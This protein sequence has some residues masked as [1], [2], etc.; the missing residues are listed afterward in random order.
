MLGVSIMPERRFSGTGPVPGESL[1]A[2]AIFRELTP[3]V[4]AMLSQRC[5][6]RSYSP[7]QMILQ[8]QDEGRD[9]YF[10]VRGRVCAVYYS[11][12]GREVHF[13]DL[14]AG[15]IFGEFAAIDGKSRATDIVS[16]TDALI[17][18]MSA[19][20]FWEVLRRYEPVCAATL[21]RL[22]GIARA[23]V[24]RVVELST[25]PVRSRVHSELLRLAGSGARGPNRTIAIINPAPTHAEIASRIST[26]REAVTRELN[27]LAR[28]DLIEKRGTALVIRDIGALANMVQGALEEPPL[29]KRR[30]A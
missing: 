18:R 15:E 30:A 21:R 28:A 19:D 9:V 22:T 8:S 29:T 5:R 17:A 25:L 10:V 12:S 1:A 14:P 20:L 3:E 6:W 23:A 7:G 24:Q 11:A 26:H 27:S 13:N 2:I 4:I 16:V